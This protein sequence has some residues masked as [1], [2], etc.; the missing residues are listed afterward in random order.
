M[1]QLERID[2]FI[3]SLEGNGILNSE[4]LSV[5]LSSDL[6]LIGGDNGLCS[7]ESIATCQTNLHCVNVDFC[8]GAD[9]SDCANKN[10]T[11]QSCGGSIKNPCLDTNLSPTT[12]K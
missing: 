9:N 12:C 6:D 2:K 3:M 5:I 4:N 7:N 1:N 8:L 11:L 10:K